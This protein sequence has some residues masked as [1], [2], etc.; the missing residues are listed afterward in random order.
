MACPS[1]SHRHV[2]HLSK[3]EDSMLAKYNFLATKCSILGDILE[4]QVR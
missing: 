1:Q 2:L 3:P 4:K